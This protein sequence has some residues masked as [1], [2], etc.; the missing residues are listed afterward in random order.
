MNES[1]N[2]SINQ[3]CLCKRRQ[4][5]V[6]SLQKTDTLIHLLSERL[7]MKFVRVY[8]AGMKKRNSQR[9]V[10]LISRP[11][12]PDTQRPDGRDVYLLFT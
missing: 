1:I 8:V 11:I 7:V 3:V 9:S 6:L 12:L 10:D 4:Q 2:Q 5:I